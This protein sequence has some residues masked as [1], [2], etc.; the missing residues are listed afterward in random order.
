MRLWR[1]EGKGK[2]GPFIVTVRAM[3]YSEAKRIVCKKRNIVEIETIMLVEERCVKKETP[4]PSKRLNNAP[5][6]LHQKCW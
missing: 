5:L 4:P 1:I 2:H 6:S 3:D